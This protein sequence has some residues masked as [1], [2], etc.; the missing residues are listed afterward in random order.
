MERIEKLKLAVKKGF[1][2]CPDTGN[3]TSPTGKICTK[4]SNNGYIMLTV[5]DENAFAYYVYGHQ[6][7]WFVLY[8][9]TVPLIDHENRNRIDNR[10][11]NLRSITNSQNAM[12]TRERNGYFYCKRSKKFIAIIMVNYKRK[13]LGS[14]NT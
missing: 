6:F 1:T 7:A 11:S 2:Y 12:N 5:R 8:N 3:I 14:F 10:K 9:E 4:K 13:Q